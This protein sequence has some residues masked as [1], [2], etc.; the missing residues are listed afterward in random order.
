MKKLFVLLPFVL[1]VVISCQ[2]KKSMVE[3]DELKAKAKLEE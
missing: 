3:L 2:D 1:F